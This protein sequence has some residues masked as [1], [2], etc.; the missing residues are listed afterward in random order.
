MSL[1][2]AIK[3]LSPV[4]VAAPATRCRLTSLAGGAVIGGRRRPLVSTSLDERRPSSRVE[5]CEEGVTGAGDWAEP[6]EAQVP[7]VTHLAEVRGDEAS[8]WVPGATHPHEL[9]EGRGPRR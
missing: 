9:F 7:P 4:A 6:V 2:T 5:G 8:V 1:H 3:V